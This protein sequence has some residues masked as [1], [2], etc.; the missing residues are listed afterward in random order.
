[1][2]T[3]LNNAYKTLQ[4]QSGLKIGD[5]VQC[6]GVFDA[7]QGG[8]KCKSSTYHRTK[9]NF[10][11]YTHT[12]II[13]KMSKHSIRVRSEHNSNDA[14]NFPCFM[15]RKIGEVQQI[16]KRYFCGDV[17][18]TSEISTETKRKLDRVNS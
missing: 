9:T 16:T 5:R 10:V 2:S 8:S 6:T 11:S 15:L 7:N 18:V 17:D 12:G 1:M 4:A 13:E 3:A 14:W